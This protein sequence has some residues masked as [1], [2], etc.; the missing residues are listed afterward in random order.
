MFL[1]FLLQKV[2][3]VLK[4][5]MYSSQLCNF[6]CRKQYIINIITENKNRYDYSLAETDVTLSFFMFLK[7]KT[8]ITSYFEKKPSILDKFQ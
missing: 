4:N 3:H 8:L 7:V 1:F 2:D 6:L 5:Y